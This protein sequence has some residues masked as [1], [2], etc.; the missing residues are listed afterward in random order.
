MKSFNNLFDK[1]IKLGKEFKF[2]CGAVL[3]LS[4]I[5]SFLAI[6]LHDKMF[7]ELLQN[8][9]GL[10][11]IMYLLLCG[12][13]SMVF[14][15]LMFLYRNFFHTNI[16][17]MGI[18]I[19]LGMQR[20]HVK[21][22][23]LS[24]TTVPI[25]VATV[26]GTTLGFWIYDVIFLNKIIHIDSNIIQ[27]IPILKMLSIIVIF[28]LICFAGMMLNHSLLN[29]KNI[30][31]IV[32][33]RK[34]KIKRNGNQRTMAIIGFVFLVG[35]NLLLLVNKIGSR[36]YSN[37]VPIASAFAVILGIYLFIYSFGYWFSSSL[38]PNNWN[39]KNLLLLNEFRN[40]YKNI[41]KSM[42]AY[43]IIYWVL[44]FLTIIIV[45]LYKTNAELDNSNS[46]YDY[47]FEFEEQKYDDIMQ[48][49]QENENYLQKY[50]IFKSVEAETIYGK[51]KITLIPEDV[52]VKLK[53]KNLCIE[54]GHII[55]LSQLDRSMVNIQKMPD[56]RE[57]HYFEPDQEIPINVGNHHISFIAD[58]EI[59]DYLFNC[60]SS[61]QRIMILNNDD[62]HLVEKNAFI[63]YRL[64]LNLI[65]NRNL[66]ISNQYENL[67]SIHIIS[68]QE[69]FLRIQN[70]NKV[71]IFSLI[72][73]LVILG[74]LLLFT[75]AL[76]YNSEKSSRKRDSYVQFTLG[77]HEDDRE[78]VRQ[79]S[80]KIKNYLPVFVGGLSGC[81]CSICFIKDMNA[82]LAILSVLVFFSEFIIQT[83]VYIIEKQLN[84][85]IASN[86]K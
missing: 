17:N 11:S 70:E 86:L 33:D 28:L 26:I 85:K 56:G 30:S 34:A 21:K 39:K 6:L 14:L 37:L 47:V 18:L 45:I 41:A 82:Y 49:V 76:Q 31:D 20:K 64:C 69:H 44:I 5:F 22:R 60:E 72:F 35:G 36:E 52:Y 2:Y 50:I 4:T 43:A 16:K 32:S 63:K 83:G 12:I 74:I 38:K 40:E 77:I 81:L 3:F 75:Q 29:C 15:Y 24:K 27:D 51:I 73:M 10:I 48:F 58:Y 67:Q 84:N 1:S 8:E 19:A 53:G 13:L 61:Q 23:L 54:K 78:E 66:D 42:S 71:L 57:W 65:K 25:T 68:K 9:N 46:P 62:F 79:Q 59:W 55:V 7:I 80:L